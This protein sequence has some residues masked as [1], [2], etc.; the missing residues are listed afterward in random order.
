MVGSVEG[1]SAQIQQIRRGK[2]E[3]AFKVGGEQPNLISS[4]HWILVWELG[5]LMGLVF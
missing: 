3:V 1:L 2:F 4:S 5:L